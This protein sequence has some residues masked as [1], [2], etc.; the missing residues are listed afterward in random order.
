ML[1]GTWFVRNQIL[2]LRIEHT[3]DEPE[4]IGPGLGFTFDVKSLTAQTLILHQ[5]RDKADMPFRRVG[6]V[7]SPH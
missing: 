1:S 7:R 2:Y 4:R 5:M 6:E 3:R